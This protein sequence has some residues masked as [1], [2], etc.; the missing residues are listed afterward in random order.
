M[1]RAERRQTAKAQG[2]L[3]Y[4]PGVPPPEGKKWVKCIFPP[5]KQ[6]VLVEADVMSPIVSAKPRQMTLPMCPVHG[7]ICM[8]MMWLLPQLRI[9]QGVTPGGI[10][11]PGQALGPIVPGKPLKLVP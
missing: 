4:K 10:V 2:T 11:V 5:C 8:F 9:Q 7:E 1:N 6:Q 3:K